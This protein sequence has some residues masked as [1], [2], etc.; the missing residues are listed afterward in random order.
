MG[1]TW[2]DLAAAALA[3]QFPADPGSVTAMTSAVGPM[4]TQA[5]RA[6]FIGL[7]SRFPGVTKDQVTEAYV[8]GRLVRGSTIRGT[9]HTSTREQFD[10]LG[11]AARAGQRRRWTQ[12]L[13]LPDDLVDDLWA[14]IEE[15]ARTWRTPDELWDHLR[16]W[17]TDHHSPSLPQVDTHPGR[18]LAFGH[19]GLVRRPASGSGWEGQGRPVY[20]T[21]EPSSTPSLADVV[22]LLPEF[23][24]LLCAYDPKARARFVDPTH[25]RLLLSEKNALMLP[26]LLV[27]GRVGGFWRAGG[28]ARRRPL[29]VRWFAD[30]RRVRKAELAEPV[31]ALEAGLGITITE[32][33]LGRA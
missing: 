28:S 31:A 12:L 29:E 3:R 30:T 2:E 5:A 16:S 11:A 24:A 33:S 1:A 32:V 23:D 26:P 20:R 25:H 4:Q 6:A 17:V 9:V 14:S 22:R 27:D 8:E 13:K 15:F 10:A 7:A 21:L 19:G 18:Y